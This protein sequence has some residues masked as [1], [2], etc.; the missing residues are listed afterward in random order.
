MYWL[1]IRCFKSLS[2]PQHA[3]CIFPIAISAIFELTQSWQASGLCLSCVNMMELAL[4][5]VW[6]PSAVVVI[7]VVTRADRT[8]VDERIDQ[9][10]SE[11]DDGIN[12][13]REE[14]QRSVAGIQDRVN[15]IRDWVQNIDRAMREELGVDLPPPTV[16]LRAKFRSGVPTMNASVTADGPASR[17]ARLQVWIKHQ[18]RNLRR[19]LRKVLVDWEEDREDS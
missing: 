19:W 5:M 14:H 11:L 16:S 18:T 12:Q 8:R 15:D 4:Y 10:S 13:L 2:K 7:G 3:I 1:F 6:Y 17:R 9:V